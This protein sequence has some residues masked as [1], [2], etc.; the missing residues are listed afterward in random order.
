M[1]GSR[2][3]PK[4]V[5]LHLLGTAININ[6]KIPRVKVAALL[7][8]GKYY[9]LNVGARPGVVASIQPFNN[10]FQMTRSIIKNQSAAS[11]FAKFRQ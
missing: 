10:R 3:T 8:T 4:L 2:M 1:H 7:F 6:H 5:N 11:A 9:S